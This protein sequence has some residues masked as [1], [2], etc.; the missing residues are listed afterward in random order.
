MQL[1]NIERQIDSLTE[2]IC[3]LAN[4]SQ[5][6]DPDKKLTYIDIKSSKHS[7]RNSFIPKG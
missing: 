7:E 5:K 2:E 4:C 1:E 3:R 6:K